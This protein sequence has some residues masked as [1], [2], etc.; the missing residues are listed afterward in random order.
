MYPVWAWPHLLGLDAPLVAIAWQL[1]VSR[2]LQP[3]PTR[4]T[5][6]LFLTVWTIYLADRL[7]DTRRPITPNEP[8][9]HRF[10]RQA[11]L[12]FTIL[13]LT[14]LVLLTQLTPLPI[15]PALPI[16]TALIAY[17][18]IV[19][20]SLTRWSKELAVATI[21]AL[22]VSLPIH[23]FPFV[24]DFL[25]LCFWNTSA[26]EYWE[27]GPTKLHPISAW[28]A[29]RLVPAAI[30]ATI[31]CLIGATTFNPTVQL[32]LALTFTLCA[33]LAHNA[34]RLS[35][36]ALRILADLVLLTPLLSL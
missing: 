22:G 21:F 6:A 19:H 18:V 10:S 33:L 30:T 29:Q 25:F 2:Q 15:T 27:Q 1:L 34:R 31:L 4:Y 36:L 26:I 5:L 7:L 24:L 23:P 16:L 9:R 20:A 35:P 11:R 3:I 12:P 8:L 28:L 17:F 32:T 14:N 13:I